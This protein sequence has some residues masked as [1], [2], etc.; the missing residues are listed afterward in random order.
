MLSLSISNGTPFGGQTV[1]ITGSGFGASAGGVTFESRAADVVSWSAGSVV[2]KTPRRS[3]GGRLTIDPTPVAVV[4]TP[5]VGAPDS[6]AYVYNCT[7]WDRI[8]AHVR[9]YLAQIHVDRGD[10]FTIGE[11]QILGLKM[12]G[13]DDTGAPMPQGAVYRSMIDYTDTATAGLDKP[14]GFATGTMKCVA[15]FVCDLGDLADWDFTLGALGADVWRALRL[16]RQA[17]PY[18]IDIRP[19]RVYPGPAEGQEDGA[20]GSV[21]VEFDIELK[22]I[23]TNMNSNTQG[24]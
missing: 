6:G 12:G 8:L 9:A 5:A 21:S 7:R 19:V 2:V 4:L 13:P 1:T 10:Y 15:Q 17:D 22:H 23:T 24:E 3:T 11:S 18:G 14:H 20:R 16:A